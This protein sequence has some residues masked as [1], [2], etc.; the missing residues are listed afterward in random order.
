MGKNSVNN[1]SALRF[2]IS[3]LISTMTLIGAKLC[4]Q[5]ISIEILH[6]HYCVSYNTNWYKIVST[7]CQ[8]W[9]P[10]YP[11]CALIREKLCQ[12]CVGI[13]ILHIHYCVNDVSIMGQ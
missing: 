5:C 4:Q 11:L 1:V 10:L 8:H 2:P 9:G 6:I 13:E 12:Q 7:M 3:I